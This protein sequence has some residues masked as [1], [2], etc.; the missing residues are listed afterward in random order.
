VAFLPL[1]PRDQMTSNKLLGI[2]AALSLATLLWEMI[3]SLEGPGSAGYKRGDDPTEEHDTPP[4][5]AG[6]RSEAW[7]QKFEWRGRPCFFEPGLYV[8]D[9]SHQRLQDGDHE[10]P[11]AQ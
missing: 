3:S 1:A 4:P 9:R 6:Q 7:A 8:P 10:K 5:P 2:V 11:A